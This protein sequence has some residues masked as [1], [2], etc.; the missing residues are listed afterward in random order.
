M[1]SGMLEDL[2]SS[3]ASIKSLV[4]LL[5]MTSDSNCAP[6]WKDAVS[7]GLV[8]AAVGDG[9]RCVLCGA[10]LLCIGEACGSE[11]QSQ[12]LDLMIQ[13]EGFWDATAELLEVAMSI[14]LASLGEKLQ[15]L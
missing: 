13:T 5:Q 9:A 11:V 14:K 3:T 1:T 4:L 7:E 12:V 10:V 2:K 15:L 6:G 8:K